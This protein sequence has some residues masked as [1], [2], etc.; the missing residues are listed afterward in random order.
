MQVSGGDFQSSQSSSA[1][2]TQNERLMEEVVRKQTERKCEQPLPV[3][4]ARVQVRPDWPQRG[5]GVTN[6]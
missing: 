1:N 5:S 4:V 2:K 3:V 6:T